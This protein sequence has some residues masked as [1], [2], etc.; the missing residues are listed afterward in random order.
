[1]TEL[2]GSRL[3]RGVG[4]VVLGNMMPV[5]VGILTAPVL[6]IGVGV[7]GRGQVAAGT[8]PLLL[9]TA[10]M[11][12]GLP[13]AVTYLSIRFP[14]SAR[15][16]L[17]LSCWSIAGAGVLAT[18]LVWLVA[19]PLAGAQVEIRHLI[20]L[21][22]LALVPTLMVAVLRGAAAAQHRWRLVAADQTI[23]S[24]VRLVLLVGLMLGGRLTPMTATAAIAV[25]PLT[26]AI[27]YLGLRRSFPPAY[28]DPRQDV[29]MRMVAGYGMRI[30]I[31]SVSGILLARLDQTLMT[32]LSSARELG[33]YAVA[34]SIS[35]VT[36][37]INNAVRDVTF[38][39]DAKDPSDNRLCSSAR[40]SGLL[41]IGLGVTIC[42]S[43]PFWLPI[44]FG[45]DFRPAIGPC[46]VLIAAL[47]LGTPG[48]VAGAGLSA[49]GHP[50]L[51]SL[52]LTGGCVV[53]VVAIFALVPGGGAIGAAIATLIGSIV[54]A[55]GNIVLLW[56]TSGVPFIAFYGLRRSDV[57][58]V[59]AFVSAFVEKSS[60]LRRSRG[61]AIAQYAA[62]AEGPPVTPS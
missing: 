13:E 4:L 56:R 27:A 17:G 39:T 25:S 6:A 61:P 33:L 58:L 28:S 55:N 46:V 14:H 59:R 8:A 53:N 57:A 37:V 22:S 29:A 31:G 1:M 3:G 45:D 34:V 12:L 11:T 49:R 18:A 15:R 10:G 32:P 23:G 30:W 42:G 36:I 48:S 9:A 16:V 43:I 41:S 7:V 19:G 5:V 50:G 47:T 24:L 51:R 44:V 40:I 52:A 60:A 20:M 62:A 2:P 38:A 26:G 35:E 54:A 21:A